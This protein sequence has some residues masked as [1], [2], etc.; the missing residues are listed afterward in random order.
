MGVR[1]PIHIPDAEGHDLK[2]DPSQAQTP[3]QFQ[4]ALR[5][6]R[7]WCGAP[8]FR[9]MAI[10]CR[11]AKTASPLREALV[12]DDLPKLDVLRAILEGLEASPRDRELFIQAWERLSLAAE[13]AGGRP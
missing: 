8:S 13:P 11:H 3:F 10:R 6:Y 4:D 1:N 9:K 7:L 5:T 2:P 12:A